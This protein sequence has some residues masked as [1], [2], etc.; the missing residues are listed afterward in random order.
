MKKKS[1]VE[2]GDVI[3]LTDGRLARVTSPMQGSI[4]FYFMMQF[5][6]TNGE[7]MQLDDGTLDID[8]NLG[9]SEEILANFYAARS[10]HLRLNDAKLFS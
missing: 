5:I 4:D 2:E 6:D 8:R 7:T 1:G 9:Q 3:L 10:I